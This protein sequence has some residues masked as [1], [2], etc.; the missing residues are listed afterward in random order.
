M[1][2]HGCHHAFMSCRGLTAASRCP[3]RFIE[4]SYSINWTHA[5]SHGFHGFSPRGLDVIYSL[6][7]QSDNALFFL[8]KLLFSRDKKKIGAGYWLN[9]F[10][11]LALYD[12]L[13]GLMIIIIKG[14]NNAISP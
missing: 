9:F 11:Y 4:D 13:T 3:R 14:K 7:K 8:R 2:F 6:Q 10:Q 5:K 12:T 1:L